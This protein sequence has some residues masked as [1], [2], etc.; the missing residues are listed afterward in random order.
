MDRKRKEARNEA[1]PPP[2][3]QHRRR[4]SPAQGGARIRG[5]RRGCGSDRHG[6]QY[7][8]QRSLEG[9]GQ[10]NVRRNA[11]RLCPGGPLW[12]APL[13]DCGSTG[14]YTQKES[15]RHVHISAA[16][17]AGLG[18]PFVASTIK[19]P[20]NQHGQQAYQ[21]ADQSQKFAS[22]PIRGTLRE[23]SPTNNPS[24]LPRFSSGNI[25]T[26]WWLRDHR[27]PASWPLLSRP[28]CEHLR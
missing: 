13:A 1:P 6:H 4:A 17:A 15:P 19:R 28:C 14:G 16:G 24:F 25:P 22:S 3:Q 2:P 8:V 23:A 18:L 12:Q 10:Q 11:G 5:R 26:G 20:I 9:S 27:R 7:R 21:R